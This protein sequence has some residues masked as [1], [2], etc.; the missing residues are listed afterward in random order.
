MSAEVRAGY[1]RTD[2]G[3]IPEDWESTTIGGIASSTRNAIVGG[4]FGSDLVATD[5][6]SDGVPVIRGQN[7][8]G[9]AVSGAFAFVTMQK[10][11]SLSANLAHPGDIVVTQRGTLGQVSLVPAHPYAAYLISQSQ[12]K[13]TLD[14]D[15]ADP[16][17][18]YYVLS[19]ELHQRIISLSAI[20]TGVPHINLGILR[21]IPVQR[22]PVGEQTAIAAVL[23]QID[24]L[25]RALDQLVAKKRG[26]KQ[27]AMQQLLTKQSRLATFSGSWRQ[28]LLADVIASLEAGVSVNAD[29]GEQGNDAHEISILKTSALSGGRFDPAECK[30][31]AAV[32][33]A[34]ARLNPE[35]DTILISRMNTPN[36][37]GECGYVDRDYPN[38]FVPDRLWM[39]RFK[40]DA[41]L[42]ALWLSYLLNTSSLKTQI[43]AAAT[44][45][46]GSMKNLSKHAFLQ[47]P[48]LLPSIDEQQAIA[49]VLA[50]MDAEL[51]ALEA[52]RDK[53]L[54][55]KQAMMQE[56]LTGNTRL[57]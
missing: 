20:Q 5:Y 33:I 2:V 48:I 52:R 4:P 12:M 46:S 27:A 22:P 44:G 39:T 7:M 21:R 30:K 43:A 41:G 25:I 11:K 6:V 40:R 24:A 31:I 57:V 18:Y 42:N 50:D 53:T 51:I 13:V 32:D 56:L 10:A 28:V 35:R 47:I 45:T 9:P 29:S 16:L 8:S 34:R 38:L 23:G 36:L 17:F 3:L 49:A 55:L 37:V 14:P 26:L 15:Q 54:A 19:S 1:K